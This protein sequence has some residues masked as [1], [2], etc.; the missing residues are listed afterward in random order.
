M[1]QCYLLWRRTLYCVT[2]HQQ[3]I[4]WSCCANE[5]VEVSIAPPTVVDS[6]SSANM[7]ESLG[8]G[9]VCFTAHVWFTVSSA[10]H[11]CTKVRLCFQHQWCTETAGSAAV[12]ITDV[13]EFVWLGCISQGPLAEVTSQRF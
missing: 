10:T 11:C 4:V 13:E 1:H 3:W 9:Q 6:R 2:T 7:T 12:C 5:V 8:A